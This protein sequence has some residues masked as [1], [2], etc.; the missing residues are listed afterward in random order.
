MVQNQ[1]Y[2]FGIGAPPI[3]I[4]FSG[5]WDVHW[6]YGV[7]THVHLNRLLAFKETQPCGHIFAMKASGAEIS[8]DCGVPSNGQRKLGTPP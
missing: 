7:L 1:W 8:L 6:G 4:Y 3:L 5:D 2:H